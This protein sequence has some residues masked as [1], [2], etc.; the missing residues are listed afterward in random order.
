MFGWMLF[1][2]LLAAIVARNDPNVEVPVEVDRGVIVT[3]ADGWYSAAEV[4]DVGEGG[5]TLR[6]SGVY[7]A[8]WVEEYQG[9][10][11]EYMAEWLESLGQEFESFRP[12]PSAAVTVGGDLP[13][14]VVHF[15]GISAEL[16]REEDEIVVV[17]YGGV[18]VAMWAR[19]EAGQLAW[20][21]GDLEEMLG[22]LVVPR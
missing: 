7:V 4:W 1:A 20:V 5:L 12:L 10:N 14:L 6:S 16:G 11:D 17:T 3:P 13:G 18:G 19:A 15:S 22:N 9:S 2:F 8:F 21:Q